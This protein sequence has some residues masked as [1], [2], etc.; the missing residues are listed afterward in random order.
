MYHTQRLGLRMQ[1][2]DARL[3]CGWALQLLEHYAAHNAGRVSLA[4]APRLR[5]EAAADTYRSPPNPQNQRACWVDITPLC[6]TVAGQPLDAPLHRS[7]IRVLRARN[8]LCE[9]GNVR[10]SLLC[11]YLSARI[12]SGR[13]LH[14]ACRDVKALLVLLTHL[15]QRDLVDFGGDGPGAPGGGV[16]V[17]KVG[18]HV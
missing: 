13:P 8:A 4:A 2:A 3:L 15:T 5:A 7:W 9:D 11:C 12:N 6:C 14:V 18:W 17:A 16:D 1:A 10:G